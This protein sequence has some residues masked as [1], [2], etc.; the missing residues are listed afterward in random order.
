MYLV[1][2]LT[3][4]SW[5]SL[6]WGNGWSDT[7]VFPL[8]PHA[9]L[10]PG[11]YAS[12]IRLIAPTLARLRRG[13]SLWVPVTTNVVTT[14]AEKGDD[15]WFYREVK[16]ALRGLPVPVAVTHGCAAAPR[17]TDFSFS[18]W[19]Y[20]QPHPAPPRVDVDGIGG[21]HLSA[22]ALNCLR[23]LARLGKACTAEIASLAGLSIP[24]ARKALKVLMGR[25]FVVV[26]GSH[27]SP[28]W[29]IKRPGVSAAL[30]SW[31]VPL[32]VSFEKRKER[33]YAQGRH[34]R[35][36]RLWLS[37]LRRAWPDAEVWTGWSEV[38]LGGRL[39]PDALAW[40]RLDGYETLFWAEMD[41]GHA[42]HEMIQRKAASRFN[43]AVVYARQFD[44]RL[45]FALLS[46]PWAQKTG[47]RVFRNLPEMAAVIVADWMD[48]GDL[49]VPRWGM[50]R[51]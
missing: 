20:Y 44:I 45:V 41:S 29:E 33:A 7:F 13:A 16:A 32:S 38:S 46:P 9:G 42:S 48:S 10:P 6:Y 25:R 14:N 17:P 30:R 26:T 5:Q 15:V 40:G 51:K 22:N 28:V 27:H 35:M 24:T 36:A 2:S 49:P 3:F 8:H 12:V 31:H 19:T 43:Q 39:R 37:R 50:A 11:D 21:N 23:V 47:L 1:G 18:P 4:E 34:K